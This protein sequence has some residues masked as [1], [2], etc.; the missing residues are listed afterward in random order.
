MSS[1]SL[2]WKVGNGHGKC[3]DGRKRYEGNFLEEIV[4]KLRS[5]EW[6]GQKGFSPLRE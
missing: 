6:A 5:R 1:P 2:G 4:P 3:W